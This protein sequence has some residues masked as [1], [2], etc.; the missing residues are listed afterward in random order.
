MGC[1]CG[2]DAVLHLT[3][4]S[5]QLV[6]IVLHACNGSRL[7]IISQLFRIVHQCFHVVC[8]RTIVGGLPEDIQEF[9]GSLFLVAEDGTA[10][11]I[12]Q[13]F[14]IPAIFHA[15]LHADTMTFIHHAV[16]IEHHASCHMIHKDGQWCVRLVRTFGETVHLITLTT[17]AAQCQVVH[18]HNRS[19]RLPLLL[20]TFCYHAFP[21]SLLHTALH[22]QLM[23][24]V[25]ILIPEMID[26]TNDSSQHHSLFDP[27]HDRVLRGFPLP[28]AD[29]CQQQEAK[30]QRIVGIVVLRIT[31]TNSK[32]RQGRPI[33]VYNIGLVIDKIVINQ[34][35][36]DDTQYSDN[37]HQPFT[38]V[39]QCHQ[40][41]SCQGIDTHQGI[42]GQRDHC[43]K[44]RTHPLLF[45]QLAVRPEQGD[46][47]NHA[48]GRYKEIATQ[49]DN[50][51]PVAQV[52][53]GHQQDGDRYQRQHQPLL[54]D[55]ECPLREPHQ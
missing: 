16:L 3:F 31:I 17:Q 43:Y 8:P 52:H 25:G 38:P 10:C 32:H 7:R 13:Q 21:V 4:Y 39:L 28:M 36:D 29:Q 22:T 42:A 54:R 51:D 30:S 50:I 1:Q 40:D 11:H 27:V 45:R 6:R 24:E 37:A 41:D 12:S 35:Y 15:V 18:H 44:D 47:G 46:S 26:A 19:C 9:P 55:I 34:G 23:V 48:K 53:V 20:G 49:L 14:H 2:H 33:D 5:V